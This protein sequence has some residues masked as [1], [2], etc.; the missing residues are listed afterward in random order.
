MTWSRYLSSPQEDKSGRLWLSLR[1]HGHTLQ[2]F[3]YPLTRNSKPIKSIPLI[4][5]KEDLLPVKGGGFMHAAWADFLDFAVVGTG[6]KIWVADRNASRIFRIN[7]VD[8][9]EDSKSG[10]Y[11][12]IVLGQN[13]LTDQKLHQGKERCSARSLAWAYNVDISPKGELLIA[14]NGGECGTD[15]RILIYEPGRFP[16]KP[17]KC[18][19]A[20]DIGDPDRVI[21]TVV[22][23]MN[24]YSAQRFPLVYLYPSNTTQPQMALGDMTGYPTTCFID[25]N[26]NV[27]IGD[28]NWSR[29]LIY[30]K[31]FAKI[32]Y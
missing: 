20:D 22:A 24:G 13:N 26:G 21:G 8:G 6:D 27:Y 7:N 12:D 28:W 19:F 15:Q 10:P 5:N 3:E 25:K 31:P 23:G 18:L 4:T 16:N 1:A 32:E 29:V 17:D 2:A 14:D 30:K 11:V 9:L